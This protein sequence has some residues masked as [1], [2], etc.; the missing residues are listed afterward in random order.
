MSSNAVDP[1]SESLRRA[2]S[3][4]SRFDRDGSVFTVCFYILPDGQRGVELMRVRVGVLGF[5]K[6]L[7][8][9]GAE[10]EVLLWTPK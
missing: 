2:L 1:A 9:S 8:L 10:L 6:L 3:L 5:A 7:D 4:A